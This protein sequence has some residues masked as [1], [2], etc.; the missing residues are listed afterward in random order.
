MS[1]N[2][3]IMVCFFDV[4]WAMGD[5]GCGK[6]EVECWMCEVR[7]EMLKPFIILH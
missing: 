7:C 3:F 4:G 5:V 2:L 6:W 1:N